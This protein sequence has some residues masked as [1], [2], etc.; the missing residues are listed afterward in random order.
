LLASNIWQRC[1]ILLASNLTMRYPFAP[2][3]PPT[4]LRTARLYPGG[5]L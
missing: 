5:V 2:G 4:R 3:C 1:Q